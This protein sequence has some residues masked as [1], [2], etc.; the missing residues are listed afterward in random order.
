MFSEVTELLPLDSLDQIKIRELVAGVPVVAAQPRLLRQQPVQP[1]IAP[2]N[3]VSAGGYVP[4]TVSS[5][6]PMVTPNPVTVPTFI[7][8]PNVTGVPS[9]TIPF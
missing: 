4:S 6:I 7:P 1:T 3:P 2:S 8:A 9:R 5:P